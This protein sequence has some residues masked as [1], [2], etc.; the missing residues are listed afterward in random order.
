MNE[1]SPRDQRFFPRRSANP[2]PV[3]LHRADPTAGPL[4]GNVYDYSPSGLSIQVERPLPTGTVLAVHLLNDPANAR[5]FHVLVENCHPH[6]GEYRLGCQ[7]T[8]IQHWDDLQV[9]G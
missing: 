6:E 7:F 2:V 5:G 3:L 9:F 8:A 4:A 1:L